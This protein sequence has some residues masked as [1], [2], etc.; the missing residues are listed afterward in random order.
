MVIPLL[1]LLSATMALDETTGLHVDYQSDTDWFVADK[2]L[3]DYTYIESVLH[4]ASHML[5]IF[6]KDDPR[7]FGCHM[8]VISERFKALTRNYLVSNLKAS[9]LLE[10]KALAVQSLVWDQV[11][12][13]IPWA[14]GKSFQ[15]IQHR[16][17]SVSY[18]RL[19]KEAWDLAIDEYKQ[20]IL[21]QESTVW[22]VEQLQMLASK[23]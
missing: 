5:T 7:R 11:C 6:D 9:D 15:N 3:G 20:D 4:E 23:G 18:H 19:D 10:C 17:W 8:A 16:A 14:P 13:A 1:S 2:N 22:L 21:V 12:Q